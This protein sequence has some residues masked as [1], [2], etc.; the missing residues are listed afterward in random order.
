MIKVNIEKAL[1]EFPRLINSCVER[2]RTI[3]IS[4]KEGDVVLISEKT[5]NKLLE[6][7]TLIGISD[8]RESIMEGANTPLSECEKIQWK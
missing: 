3:K 1:Q 4:T 6:S 2:D 8:M 5:Y 7:F